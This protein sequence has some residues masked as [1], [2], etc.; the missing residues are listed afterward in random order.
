MRLFYST[1]F[2][3][4]CRAGIFFRFTRRKKRIVLERKISEGI[5]D[6]EKSITFASLLAA[7]AL[8]SATKTRKSNTD[9]KRKEGS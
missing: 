4:K 8:E 2:R 5:A 6:F 3:E 7:V 9:K 1:L